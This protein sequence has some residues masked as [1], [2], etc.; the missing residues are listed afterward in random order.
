MAKRE[1]F[2]ECVLVA[3]RNEYRFH[4]RAWTAEEAELHFREELRS[5]GVTASGEL[6][7]LDRNGG[8]ARRSAYA[9]DPAGVRA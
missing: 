3:D 5:N 8:L 9:P 6:Q 1:P 4:L 2:F 7:V